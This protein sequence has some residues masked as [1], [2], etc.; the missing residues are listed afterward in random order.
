MGWK[1]WNRGLTSRKEASH[2][3]MQAQAD[4]R[5]EK[6]ARAVKILEEQQSDWDKVYG[7]QTAAAGVSVPPLDLMKVKL[8]ASPNKSARTV[9]VQYI[10]LHHTGPGSFSGI[11][12]WLCNPAARASAHYVD[13]PQGQLA[14]LVN[15]GKEA[16]HAG[17]ALYKGKRIDNHGSI[18]IELT[19]YGVMQR[20]DDGCFYYEYG[21]ALKKYRGKGTPVPASITYPDG[22][23]LSGYVVPYTSKQIDKLVALCKALVIKYPQI[24]RD[25]I[26]T[27]FEIG[28]PMGRKSDPFGLSMPTIISRVFDNK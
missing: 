4:L 19:N 18:G 20:G 3:R 28:Y 6:R 25:N 22:T 1:F 23:V 12:K 5:E 24:T 8:Y 27:H 15:T 17:R 2:R 13:G 21:R 26:L 14:Q 10:V 7:L 9:P 16:W 11:V